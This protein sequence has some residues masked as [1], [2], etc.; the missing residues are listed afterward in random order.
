MEKQNKKRLAHYL[1]VLILTITGTYACSDKSSG[2]SALPVLAD[3]RVLGDSSTLFIDI[4]SIKRL[5]DNEI[6]VADRGLNQLRVFGIDG[7]LVRHIG[8]EG[9]GPGEFRNIGWASVDRMGRIAVFDRGK[10]ARIL[11]FEGKRYFSIG[12]IDT[13]A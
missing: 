10:F 1:T 8:L 13:T 12:S 11:V 3:F 6:L 9:S 5:S 2:A 4:E 7:E